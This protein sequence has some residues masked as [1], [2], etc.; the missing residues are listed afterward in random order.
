MFNSVGVSEEQVFGDLYLAWLKD[1]GEKNNNDSRK[2]F[3]EVMEHGFSERQINLRKERLGANVAA[4]LA[5]LLHRSPLTRLDLHGNTL[6]DSGCEMI[7]HLVRDLPGLLYL[8]LGANDIGSLGIQTLSFVVATHKKLQTLILGS[9]KHDAYANRIN[10]TSATILLEGCLRSRTLRHI[11]LSGSTIGEGN[12]CNGNSKARGAAVEFNVMPPSRTPSRPTSAAARKTQMLP[13]LPTSG[14]TGVS[15]D[16]STNSIGFGISPNRRPIDVLA[17]LISTSST[18]TTLKLREVQL[19]TDAA[20]SIIHAA[21]QSSSFAFIDLSGNALSGT[22]GDALGDLVRGRVLLQNTSALHTI[23]LNDNMLMRPNSG[24]P[25]PRLFS[26]LSSD[27]IVVRLHLD[28]CGIDDAAMEPLCNSL[29]TNGALQSL[30]LKNNAITSTGAVMLASSLFRHACLQDVSLEGN[31]VRDEGACAFASMLE[32]NT[33]LLSLNLTHTWMGERGVV[34]IGV[35]LA[36]NKTLQRLYLGENH[37]TE[38]AGAAFAALLESNRHLLRCGLQGNSIGHHTVLN[39]EKTTARNR[40]TYRNTEKDELEKDLIRL[41]Y[42]MYKLD[43]ARA[44]LEN[45]QQKK[46]DLGRAQ[47]SFELQ[48]K[49]ETSDMAKKEREL[50]EMLENCVTQETH[51]LD[52][53]KRLDTELEEALKQTEIDMELAKER[54]EAET[55][56][57]EKVEEEHRQLKAQVEYMQNNGPQREV[58][59]R[60]QLQEINE[61]CQRWAGQRKEYR[62][63]IAEAQ[64]AVNQLLEKGSGGGHRK[65]AKKA[66]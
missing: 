32:T 10:A 4:S 48:F 21:M 45:L 57:R 65:K 28:S 46:L 6:R 42:Q 31:A 66:K 3:R 7:G 36:G 54:L 29:N 64:A 44:E 26:S 39:V 14:K 13:S 43:E 30:H 20:L 9:S 19:T 12:S 58:E 37:F 5:A 16:P 60:K 25:P 23:L 38:D 24:A 34:A 11:D 55:A 15:D 8:D 27:R 2:L 33:T 52:E 18:L 47:E 1:T 51:C 62:S 49:Q 35:S 63:A 61:D 22:V 53:K 40:E 56:V 50:Q 41:H 17:E 59:K